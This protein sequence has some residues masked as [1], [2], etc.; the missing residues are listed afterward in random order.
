MPGPTPDNPLQAIRQQIARLARTLDEVPAERLVQLA[1][2]LAAL[3]ATAENLAIPDVPSVPAA[4]A[5]PISGTPTRAPNRP[6]LLFVAL[7]ARA[8]IILINDEGCQLLG[9]QRHELIGQN[10]IELCVPERLQTEIRHVFQTL[11]NGPSADN[12]Y[13]ENPIVTRDG[14]EH[15]IAWRSTVI[16]NSEGNFLFTL[17][18]G[19]DITEQRRIAAQL[20]ETEQQYQTLLE[21]I[22]DSIVVLDRDW[23]YQVVNE[24]TVREL[25]IPREALLGTSIFDLFDGVSETEFF[26]T[27][28]QV[29][30][31]RQ[32]S[33]VLSHYRYPDGREKWYDVAVYPVPQGIL[34]IF[35]DMTD[36]QR[37][38]QALRE[39]EENFR[40]VAETLHDVLWISTPGLKRILYVSPAYE[41]VWGRSSAALHDHPLTFLDSVHPDDRAQL[42]DS[43]SEHA[44]GHWA[45]EYRLFRPDGELRWV[46]DRGFPV[47]DDQGNV[48]RMVRIT[49]DITD[50][51]RTEA[52]LADHRARLEALVERRTQALAETQDRLA[53]HERLAMLGELAGGVGHELR[54]PLGVI[55]NAVYF[56]RMI[57][58]DTTDQTREYL[59]IIDSEVKL[60]EKIVADLLDF[61]RKRP[62]ELRPANPGTLVKSVLDQHPPPGG[63][64]VITDLDA[65][66]PN[67]ILDV[68]Q[69]TQ[70]LRNLVLNAFQAMSDGGTLT[71]SGTLTTD[72]LHLHV[73]DTGPGI[74]AHNLPHIF[75]PLFTTKAR[76]IGL[77]LAVS[78]SLVENN[79]GTLTVESREGAGTTFTVSLP[80]KASDA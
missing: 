42:L 25:H 5:T 29:M 37:T 41:T 71:I 6:G 55:S 15:L 36:F 68:Q 53:R 30:A 3:Q 50:Q 34:C 60:A 19:E 17:S 58:S 72:R 76:G 67:V 16:T 62:P 32:H 26:E 27:Y 46:R 64:A 54:N 21:S 73:A 69:I 66:P 51:K 13:Y 18:S 20:A 61:A 8:D 40:T 44:R 38:Q 52:E 22:Q 39:S 10:W 77:G 80:M 24:A 28:Q 49:T 35:H 7:N 45:H 1:E 56:L 43:L 48:S 12:S 78:K 63:I 70:V 57:L 47:Y 65:L 75:E 31:T 2:P 23:R 9:Y 14:D 11:V 33:S 79:G 4:P 59:E 74:P